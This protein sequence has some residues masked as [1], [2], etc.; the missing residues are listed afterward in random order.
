MITDEQNEII[1]RAM[2]WWVNGNGDWYHPVASVPTRKANE[3][4]PRFDEPGDLHEEMIV[5]YLVSSYAY[6]DEFVSFVQGQADKTDSRHESRP[7]AECLAVLAYLAW[8]DE[9]EE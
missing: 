3:G 9:R 8:I 7:I 6:R 1:A 5:R 4:P 2:G